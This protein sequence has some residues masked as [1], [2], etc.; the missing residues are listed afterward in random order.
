MEE[1]ERYARELAQ[2]QTD[3]ENRYMVNAADY[4]ENK[5][6]PDSAQD[7]NDAKVGRSFDKIAHE[8]RKEEA[9]FVQP[10]DLVEDDDNG[11]NPLHTTLTSGF[12][13]RQEGA[14]IYAGEHE[15]IPH[16]W[17]LDDDDDDDEQFEWQEEDRQARQVAEDAEVARRLQ[18]NLDAGESDVLPL[19]TV[20]EA[21]DNMQLQL[22]DFA[23]A[24]QLAQQEALDIQY[25]PQRITRT[26]S[27]AAKE[28][29]GQ[30]HDS[31]TGPRVTTSFRATAA[32]DNT[33]EN[34][35][36]IKEN[37]GENDDHAGL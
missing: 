10:T 1:D 14:S 26:R 24:Q 27:Q 32:S 25:G 34:A 17:N 20:K 6:R 3:V 13:S 4:G 9:R 36:T 2:E 11:Y 28:N 33:I 12:S 19:F 7:M 29:D 30:E 31:D 15:H 35:E 21:D 16:L 8:K 37:D 23:V 5:V 18:A 22:D